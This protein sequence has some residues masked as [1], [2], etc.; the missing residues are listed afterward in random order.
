MANVEPVVPTIDFDVLLE[1]IPG[2][3]PSGQSMRYSGTLYSDIQART[4]DDT[5]VSTVNGKLN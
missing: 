2:D 5:S 4:A 1:P 3:N